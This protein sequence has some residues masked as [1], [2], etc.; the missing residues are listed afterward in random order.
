[1]S[2]SETSPRVP[3]Y[4]RLANDLRAAI[5]R[6]EYAPG[7]AL[8]HLV[9]LAARYG[10]AKQT[11]SQAITELEDEGLVQAVR[12]RGTV[13]RPLPSPEPLPLGLKGLDDALVLLRPASVAFA[14]APADVAARMGLSSGTEVLVHDRVLGDREG[15]VLCLV[16]RYLPAAVA[17]E[18]G[19][20]D[21]EV[22]KGRVD[23]ALAEAE[24]EYGPLRRSEVITARPAVAAER[25]V[26]GLPRGVC[27]Q[28]V[29]HV[30]TGGVGEVLELV[31]WRWSA[32]TFELTRVLRG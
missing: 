19:L 21:A 32:E 25:E 5:A 10:M 2:A 29:L 28:R 4:R 12:R 30:L 13:V 3:A 16:T 26:L 31:D 17:R 9:D 24:A 8:P 27:L 14:P 22:L 15:T 7:D 18:L 1:M 6:G 20:G 11:A 23:A